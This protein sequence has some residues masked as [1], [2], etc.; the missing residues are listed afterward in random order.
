MAAAST[1]DRPFARGVAPTQR[2]ADPADR[3]RRAQGAVRIGG[4]VM[5]LGAAVTLGVLSR[6]PLWLA[7]LIGCF[8]VAYFTLVVGFRAARWCRLNS[9]ALAWNDGHPR[10]P[11]ALDNLELRRRH[12]HNFSAGVDNERASI[13]RLAIL[14][15]ALILAI[16]LAATP[17]RG[18]IPIAASTIAMIAGVVVA[19]VLHR[20]VMCEEVPLEDALEIDVVGGADQHVITAA[21]DAARAGA[22]DP[23]EGRAGTVVN[24]AGRRLV[25]RDG[26]DDDFNSVAWSHAEVLAALGRADVACVPHLEGFDV[27]TGQVVTEAI[28]TVPL[29]PVEP[30]ELAAALAEIR[31]VTGLDL[32][33]NWPHSHAPEFA[34]RL[35]ADARRL[36][37]L[38]REHFDPADASR[39]GL[40]EDPFD[41]V[42]PNRLASRTFTLVHGRLDHDHLVRDTSGRLRIVGWRQAT[43]GDP[44]WDLARYLHTTQ[45][46]DPGP[47]ID[48]WLATFDPALDPNQVALNLETWTEIAVAIAAVEAI[49]ADPTRLDTPAVAAAFSAGV[50]PSPQRQDQT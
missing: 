46:A 41:Q 15:P 19:W 8:G 1:I 30:A 29:G 9:V 16:A 34:Q 4:L 2:P 21:L 24:V 7:A 40:P 28:E 39:V 25:V 36:Y 23:L 18:P 3:D 43:W 35:M 22:G 31:T 47:Y 13:V 27:E 10:A 38:A 44:L 17:W 50:W 45:P 42:R 12:L 32:P 33:A 20:R 6:V 5:G 49:A 11:I 37:I 26:V 14:Q 48:A